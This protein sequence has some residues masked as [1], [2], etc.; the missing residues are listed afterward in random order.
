MVTVVRGGSKCRCRVSTRAAARRRRPGGEV[1]LLR[2]RHRGLPRGVARPRCLGELRGRAGRVVAARGRDR[3]G[4]PVPGRRAHRRA[5]VLRSGAGPLCGKAARSVRFGQ[6]YRAARKASITA[7]SAIRYQPKGVKPMRPITDSTQR[8]VDQRH[9]EGGRGSPP[10]S[11]RRPPRDLVARLQQAV[12]GGRQH[13]RDGEDEAELGRRAP[14]HPQQQRGDDGG[15]GARGAGDH[16]QRL[17][18]ADQQRRQRP[19]LR[20]RA[21]GRRRPQPL[22]QDDGDAAER[23]ARCRPPRG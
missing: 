14:V 18:E 16:R 11:G 20:H 22:D 12:G 7:P 21:D 13:G 23:S 3:P 6:P 5:A 17:A 9:D 1:E 8:T 10:R 15:A 19:D 2:R 4:V